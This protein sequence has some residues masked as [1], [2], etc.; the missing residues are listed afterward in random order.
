M[1]A[2]TITAWSR[3]SLLMESEIIII[4]KLKY[5]LHLPDLM[6]F[7]PYKC[8]YNYNWQGIEFNFGIKKVDLL[9]IHTY[10][11]AISYLEN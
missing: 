7:S 8:N 3:T 4:L 1:I 10:S 5:I 6:N 9:C 11:E 2:T